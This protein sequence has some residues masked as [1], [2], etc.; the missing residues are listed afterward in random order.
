VEASKAGLRA[1]AFRHAAATLQSTGAASLDKKRRTMMENIVRKANKEEKSGKGEAL[2]NESDCKFCSFAFDEYQLVCPNCQQMSPMCVAS[3]LRVSKQ[4][5]S[6]GSLVE[7]GN[8]LT[9][10][11]DYLEAPYKAAMFLPQELIM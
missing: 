7:L 11:K 4:N 9:A 5:D 3:G 8:G 6:L 2:P 10:M 1:T